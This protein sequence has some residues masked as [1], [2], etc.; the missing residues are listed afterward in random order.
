[1]TENSAPNKLPTSAYALTV[2]VRLE[3]KP[4][5]LSRVVQIIAEHEAS[6]DE[7][8]LLHSDFHYKTREI[9][10][11]CRDEEHMQDVKKSLQSMECVALLSDRDD[12]LHYHKGGKISVESRL[13]I[14][15]SDDLAQVYSPGVARICTLIHEH[16]ETAYD[17][18]RRG[19]SVGI[20]TE[21]SAV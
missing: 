15:T 14:K 17:Y 2:R 7:L 19:P 6:L 10:I 20:V 11:K 1:M 12:V 3:N 18:T 4:G 21:G 5:R 8:S 13:D 16:E 9:T